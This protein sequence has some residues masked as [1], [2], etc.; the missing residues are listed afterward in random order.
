VHP[1]A[2]SQAVSSSRFAARRK[3]KSISVAIPLKDLEFWDRASCLEDTLKLQKN[4][5]ETLDFIK[6]TEVAPQ[7]FLASFKH[8]RQSMRLYIETCFP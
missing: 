6:K 2:C 5:T 4:Q 3:E 8:L 1:A 7:V